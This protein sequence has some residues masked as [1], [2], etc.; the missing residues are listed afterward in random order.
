VQV[1]FSGIEALNATRVAGALWFRV[2]E[3][4]GRIQQLWSALEPG[5]LPA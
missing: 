4:D 3:R 5:A 1:E 2:R